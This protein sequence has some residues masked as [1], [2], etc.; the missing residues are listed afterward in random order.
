MY[1][2]V[3]S[4]VLE[5]KDLFFRKDILNSVLSLQGPTHQLMFHPLDTF[6]MVIFAASVVAL[7]LT[8]KKNDK[9]E[10]KILCKICVKKDI[11]KR[12]GMT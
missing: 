6:L 4:C 12:N 3:K 8:K 7:T 1:D 5:L 11:G 2:K 10:K 9:R